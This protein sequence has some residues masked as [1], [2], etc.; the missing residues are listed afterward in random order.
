MQIEPS[1]SLKLHKQRHLSYFTGSGCWIHSSNI[2]LIPVYWFLCTLTNTFSNLL[3]IDFLTCAAPHPRRNIQ[4]LL[5]FNCKYS[6]RP[7]HSE[8]SLTVSDS[9]AV[10]V[11]GLR[12]RRPPHSEADDRLR[13]G[14]RSE[15]AY[16]RSINGAEGASFWSRKN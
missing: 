4:F 5:T 6:R 15:P 10:G 7:L 1:I 13:E 14:M 12:T 11:L 2:H 8:N 16:T 3:F 9:L